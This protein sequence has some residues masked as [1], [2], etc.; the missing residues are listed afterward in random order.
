MANLVAV[1]AELAEAGKPIPK[2][3]CS[4]ALTSLGKQ[5]LDVVVSTGKG[6]SCGQTSHVVAECECVQ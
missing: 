5:L 3:V 2:S 1:S 4:S 6:Q